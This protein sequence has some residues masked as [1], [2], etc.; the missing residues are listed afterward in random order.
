MA[1]NIAPEES[2]E[3]VAAGLL[4]EG[5]SRVEAWLSLPPRD[6]AELLGGRIVYQAMASIEHGA[7]AGNVFAQLDGFQG[8]PGDHGGGWWLSQEVDLLLAGQGLRPD[9]VGWRMDRH[10]AAPRRVTVGPRRLGVCTT[11][12][13]WVC[14][15]LSASTRARDESEGLKWQAYHEAGVGHYWLVDLDREQILV[16]RR[17]QRSYEAIEVAGREAVKQLPPFEAIPFQA[18]RLFQMVALLRRA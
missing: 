2:S 16:H 15:V 1:S 8:P 18:R 3:S 5:L 7:A 4:P 11:A 6:R 9:V 10:P 14:E 12:P 13:D 17:D